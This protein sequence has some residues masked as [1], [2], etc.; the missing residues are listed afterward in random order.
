MEPTMPVSSPLTPR[1]LLDR[2]CGGDQHAWRALLAIYEPLLHHWLRSAGLETADRDD[3]TQQVLTVLV[4]KLP[5]FRHSGRDGAFRA[6]LR[7]VTLREV[8]EFR[9]RGA[10]LPGLCAPEDLEAIPSPLDEL[11]GA[12]DAEYER[13]VLSGLLA[14]VEPEF[15]PSAWRAFRRIALEGGSP[16]DVAAEMG[17]TVNAVTL[18]KS[19]VLRRLRQEARGLVE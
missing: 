15:T 16:R 3:L 8:A 1:S 17:T 19:R 5:S 12:W 4:R 10:G 13:H 2:I 11:A 9:R 7:S 6:W 18:A 14:V